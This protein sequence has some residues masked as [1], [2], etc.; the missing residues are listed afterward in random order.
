MVEIKEENKDQ[1]I[2]GKVLFEKDDYKFLWLGWDK[3]SEKEIIQTNQYL[4][5]TN[6][7]GVLLDP[8]G[9]STFS[10]VV[11]IV[12]QYVN[13]TKIKD[14]FFSHQ[15]P[16]VSS[17][18]AMWLGVT[19]AKVS[20]SNKWVRFLPHFGIYDGSRIIP[21]KDSGGEIPIKNYKPLKIIP[22]HF[23][24]STGNLL[25]YDP[26]SKI[27]FSGDIGAGVFPPDKK[28]L[29]VENFDDHLKIIEAFHQRYMASNRAIRYFIDK[30]SNYEI[31]M[32][33][34]QHGAIYK[35]ENV[36][37]FLNWLYDLKC[38]VDIIETIY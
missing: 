5:T 21:I 29:F 12:S 28:Y 7:Q 10:K 18:V 35:G 3:Y 23:L 1:I 22:A 19:D 38:G 14:I 4:I 25:I 15:D 24:H 33:C 13:L 34:P 16:D 20:I 30:I 17:G 11:A 31:D 2:E 36:K 8:G 26:N 27:L 32:I 9:V 37:K 6:E